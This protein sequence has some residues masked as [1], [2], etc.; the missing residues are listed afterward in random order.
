M[1]STSTAL[2]RSTSW[3]NN[4]VPI[5][6]QICNYLWLSFCRK[7]NCYSHLQ[8]HQCYLPESACAQRMVCLNLLRVDISSTI[9][10]GT[11]NITNRRTLSA[12]ERS[13]YIKAVKCIMAKPS[14]TSK[15]LL[16]GVTNY[17]EDYLGTHILR[18]DRIHFVVS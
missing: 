1:L 13:D 10:Y 16:P 7:R 18:M 17:Y 3:S 8:S 14:I 6:P 2:F 5:P 12:I 4:G 15:T 11:K 9:I